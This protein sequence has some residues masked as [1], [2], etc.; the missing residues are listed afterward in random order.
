MSCVRARTRHEP[1]LTVR[2]HV[3]SSYTSADGYRLPASV[4]LLCTRL[5]GSGDR[6]AV[7]STMARLVSE[8]ICHSTQLGTAKTY[9]SSFE[10]GAL[11]TRQKLLSVAPSL[12]WSASYCSQQVYTDPLFPVFSFLVI[13]GHRYILQYAELQCAVS[14]AVCCKRTYHT[15]G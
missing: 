13:P 8:Q 15:F 9:A 6:C 11:S 2:T 1:Q 3:H 10:N 7:L 5:L 4:K 12:M 14:Y